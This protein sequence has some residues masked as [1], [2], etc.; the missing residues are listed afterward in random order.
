MNIWKKIIVKSIVLKDN[1]L[2]ILKE[3]IIF[4]N[5][6]RFFV[7]A[8]LL[9]LFIGVIVNFSLSPIKPFFNNETQ[10][11]DNR[12]QIENPKSINEV[13]KNFTFPI[14]NDRGQEINKIEYVISSAEI[15]NEI[16]V[17][18]Q[19]ATSIKG[20]EFLILNLKI[21]N[22]SDQRIL[23]NSRDYIRLAQVQN[24]DLMASDIHNDPVEVQAGS[25][26]MTRLGFI[27][28][29]FNKN[30]K[31]QIGEIKGKKTTIDLSFK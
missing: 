2:E 30:F 1:L 6:K 17:K 19:K 26:K 24:Q 16:I 14:K 5:F 4:L 18:G 31:I 25:T 28:D 8:S 22:N 10:I 9:I 13:N 3:K 7:L 15:R 20:R 21:K 11:S 12:V 27:V 23:I 29:D